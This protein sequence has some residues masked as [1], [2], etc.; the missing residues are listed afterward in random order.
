MEWL[1]FL[2]GCCVGSLFGI[3]FCSWLEKRRER[4]INFEVELSLRKEME[5]LKAMKD[6]G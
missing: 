4:E 1:D 2:I 6:K 3:V 5:Q